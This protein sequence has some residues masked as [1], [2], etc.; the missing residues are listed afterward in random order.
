M[1]LDTIHEQKESRLADTL[2]R[3]AIPPFTASPIMPPD[4]TDPKRELLRKTHRT[5]VA[6]ALYITRTE[7]E[8]WLG[9]LPNAYM[10]KADDLVASGRRH[11]IQNFPPQ[12]RAGRLI[13]EEADAAAARDPAEAAAVHVIVGLLGI[14]PEQWRPLLER[15]IDDHLV[16]KGMLVDWAI[17]SKRD[18]A[19]GWATHP[20]AHMI[21]TARRYRSD[22]KKGQRQRTWLY[23]ARQIDQLED[24]WL[25]ATGLQR[26]PLAA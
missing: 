21:V 2:R 10:A 18:D 24:A 5:A 13:W 9:P 22:M 25:A 11:P 6:S 26:L 19:G 16:I 1:T 17:H 12:F 20:H 15:F 8:D 3:S 23:S 4:P 14:A 7:G